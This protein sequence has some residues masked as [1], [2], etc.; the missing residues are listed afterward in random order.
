[1]AIFK[2][3]PETL[4]RVLVPDPPISGAEF[5]ALCR[6]NDD[7][8]FERTQ[9]GAVRIDPPAG[10]SLRQIHQPFVNSSVQPFQ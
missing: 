2:I 4:P 3:D 7:V 5:E 9:D 8:Q 6:E 1:M 10:V